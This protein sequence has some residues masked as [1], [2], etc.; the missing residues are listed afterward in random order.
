MAL[1]HE[2]QQYSI[3]RGRVYFDP[4]DANGNL[5]GEI[6]FGN[7]PDVTLNISVE[8]AEHFSS[9]EGLREKDESFPV[10]VDRTGGLACDNMTASNFA[11]WL[12]GSREVK[13]QTATP[14]VG[15]LRTVVPG[16]FY[17]LGST[18]A[19]PMGVRNVTAITVKDQ[20]GTTTYV[21]GTD[22]NVELETG[23]VQIM[24][25]GDITAG[26]VQFGYTPVAGTWEAVKSGA[27]TETRGAL[28]IVS[29][30]ASGGNRDFFMPKVSLVPDGD[31]PI[32]AE[33]TEFVSLNFSLEVL[34][35]AN[36]EA[37]YADGRPVAIP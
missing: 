15:E 33:G 13:S 17:Q 11:L 6:P 23:R 5:T 7:C 22:Y 8:K 21:A 29:K 4:E 28:R 20:A 26:T 36:T 24:P 10:Q 34:K 14:V 9:M 16:R 2:K 35:G 19:N 31:M 32:I 30:N 18:T 27:A 25:D 37:I 1:V 12:S 3:P